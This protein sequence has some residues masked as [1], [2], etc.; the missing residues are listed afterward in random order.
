MATNW[1]T[2]AP[3]DLQKVMS[4]LV[5]GATDAN[6]SPNAAPNAPIDPNA[7]RRQQDTLTLTIQNIRGA[8]QNTGRYPLSVT[9]GSVPPEAEQYALVLA[10][11]IMTAATPR[12]DMVVASVTGMYVPWKDLVKDAKTWLKSVQD[13]DSVTTPTDPTGQDYLTPVTADNPA[14]QATHWGDMYGT[15]SQYAAGVNGSNNNFGPPDMTT[16]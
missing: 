10:A 14:I 9:P 11:D 12:M 13:G 5:L 7:A 6:T 2:P 8:I 1:K 16:D 15:D 4:A 3:A